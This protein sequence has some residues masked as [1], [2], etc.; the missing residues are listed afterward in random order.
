MSCVCELVP[1]LVHVHTDARICSYCIFKS[2]S[3]LELSCTLA[4]PKSKAV[5]LHI[6]LHLDAV[7]AALTHDLDEWGMPYEAW[8]EKD[9]IKDWED[10]GPL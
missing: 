1:L 6:G 10:K 5:L 9:R 4:L 3:M 8:P 7:Y 2:V